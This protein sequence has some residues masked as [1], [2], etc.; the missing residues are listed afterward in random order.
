VDR[1]ASFIDEH[2]IPA[3]AYEYAMLYGIQR[4]LQLKLVLQGRPLRVLIAYGDY[5]FPWYM[6]RLAERPANVWF[7]LKNLFAP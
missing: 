1:L 4:P 6:R 7:V 3:S 5:W 2:R